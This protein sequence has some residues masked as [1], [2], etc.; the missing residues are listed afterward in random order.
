MPALL[1]FQHSPLPGEWSLIEAV[2]ANTVYGCSFEE[3]ISAF[4]AP[5]KFPQ[6]QKPQNPAL[7]SVRWTGRQETGPHCV[8]I[9]T[10]RPLAVQVTSH[11]LAYSWGDAR[12]FEA[13]KS[14]RDTS[15]ND[16]PI[17]AQILVH[18]CQKNPGAKTMRPGNGV[19]R[20]P[21][22]K[23]LENWIA[24]YTQEENSL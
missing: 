5:Y 1:P 12:A 4:G 13:E 15:E 9:K 21:T 19:R 17:I 8:V 14:A 18:L 10:A 11:Y 22:Q 24:H 6:S 20:N 3:S 2:Q 16:M 7:H 23:D